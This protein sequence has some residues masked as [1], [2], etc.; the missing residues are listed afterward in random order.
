MIHEIDTEL[1]REIDWNASLVVILGVVRK[2]DERPSLLVFTLK[3]LETIKFLRCLIF[4]I[5]RY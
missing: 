4:T 5:S 2:F 1:T 3:L